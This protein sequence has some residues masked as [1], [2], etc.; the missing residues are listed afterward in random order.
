MTKNPDIRSFDLFNESG[1][2]IPLSK[3]TAE[4]ITKDVFNCESKEWKS[5]EVVYVDEQSIIELNKKHLQ[6]GYITDIIT[7]HYH[8]E[9]K[10][11][12]ASLFCCAQR[13]KEQAIEF[14]SEEQTEFYRVLT[15]GILHLCGY[16]DSTDEE[17]NLMRAKENKYLKQI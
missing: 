5:V 13:I 17:K 16:D 1:T 14:G 2:N 12:E 11:V 9:D 4:K 7:F 15:H 3:E 10:P 6:K 8:D